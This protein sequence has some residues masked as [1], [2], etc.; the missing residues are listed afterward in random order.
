MCNTEGNSKLISGFPNLLK[1]I[2][3]CKD[4][5]VHKWSCVDSWSDQHPQR[6]MG[7][8]TIKSEK[9]PKAKKKKSL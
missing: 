6:Q 7:E 4:N 1:W 3:K 9:I 2:A 5:N 8:A